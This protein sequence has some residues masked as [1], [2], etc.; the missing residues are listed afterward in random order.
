[1]VE[2]RD[3][4]PVDPVKKVGNDATAGFDSPASNPT[5]HAS[6]EA[7]SS[8]TDVEGEGDPVSESTSDL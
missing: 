8:A 2:D 3:G 5:E 7:L 1:M 6:S 4:E